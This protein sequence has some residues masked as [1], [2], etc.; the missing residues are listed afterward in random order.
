[1]TPLG[2]ISEL[3]KALFQTLTLRTRSKEKCKRKDKKRGDHCPAHKHY[4]IGRGSG[5][6]WE[7][8]TK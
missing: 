3:Y 5:A 2:K 8:R 1:M 4:M 7:L 6:K